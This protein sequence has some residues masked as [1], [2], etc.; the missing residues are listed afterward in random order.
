MILHTPYNMVMNRRSLLAATIATLL[1]GALP[2]AI[3]IDLDVPY[4]E[5]PD[6]IVTL[7]LDLAEITDNDYVID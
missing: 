5:T 6:D 3:A 7:M 1:A 4:V 2:V